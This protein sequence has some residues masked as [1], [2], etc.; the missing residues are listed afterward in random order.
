MKPEVVDVLII[1]GSFSGAATAKL[2]REKSPDA[3]VVIVERNRTHERKVGEATVEVSGLFLARYLGALET[4][5]RDHIPKHGLRFWFTDH[6]RRDLHEMA[7][8]GPRQTPPEISFQ[9][10]R[11]K[12]DESI[13]E[14]AQEAAAKFLSEFPTSPLAKRVRSNCA[15]D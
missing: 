9:V 10:D 13:L 12:L 2:L 11:A 14:K 1:G 6:H 7:E 15:E 5:K 3:K 8:I 4:L